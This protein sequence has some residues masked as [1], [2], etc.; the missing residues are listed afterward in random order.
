MRLL[1][2][3]RWPGNVEQ[4]YGVLRKI[5]TKRRSGQVE[6]DDL[7]PECRATTRRVLTRVEALECDAIVDALA[8]AD[9]NKTEA[10]RLLHMSRATIYR[11]I[12]SYGI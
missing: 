2:R 11:K 9:G 7:P 3:N 5:T 6:V 12:R 4:L 1:M 10:A 8:A